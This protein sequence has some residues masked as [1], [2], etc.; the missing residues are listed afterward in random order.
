M[1]S[2]ISLPV[3]LA[4]AAI[5]GSGAT[6]CVQPMDLVKNRMQTNPGLSVG[7]CVVKLSKLMV[8]QDFGPV[9]E[10]G[11]SDNVLIRQSD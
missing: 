6:V 9:L 2:E 5:S 8:S 7:S 11:Y 1:P 10:Q 4:F 3:N